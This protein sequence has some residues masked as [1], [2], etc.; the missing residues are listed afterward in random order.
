MPRDQT[1]YA[2][3][4]LAASGT[5]ELERDYVAR[6]L[7][8]AEALRSAVDRCNSLVDRYPSLL[9]RV[10]TPVGVITDHPEQVAQATLTRLRSCLA[11][12]LRLQRRER[13][14]ASER[15]RRLLLRSCIRAMGDAASDL[16]D[17]GQGGSFLC[18]SVY[19]FPGDQPP[20]E[21]GDLPG[22]GNWYSDGERNYY[23]VV[24]LEENRCRHDECCRAHHCEPVEMPDWLLRDWVH[25]DRLLDNA[26]DALDQRIEALQAERRVLRHDPDLEVALESLATLNWYRERTV[27]LTE[28]RR[29][30]HVTGWTLE[31]DPATLHRLLDEAGVDARVLFRAGPPGHRPPVGFGS[32]HAGSPFRQFVTLAGTPDEYEIDP[33][34]MLA[35]LV[36]LLFGFMFPDLG[37]GLL[38]AIGSLLLSR[39]NP[40]LRFLV[41]CGLA[42]A[43]FGVLF[44]ETFGIA[45]PDHGLL[46]SPMDDP[47][48]VL[49][50]SLVMGAVIILIGL[51]L[52]GI[53]AY[54]RGA[55]ARWLWLDAAVLVMF[56]SA[57]LGLLVPAL[58]AVTG[59]ALVWYVAGLLVVGDHGV[60]RGLLQLAFG[61]FELLKN[62]ASFAR[63]GAFALAHS[64]LSHAL[65][66]VAD[67]FEGPFA[68]LIVL[69]IGH[70][71]IVAVE[72]LVVYV[73]TTRLLLFEF[74]TRFL[75]AEGRLF[76]PIGFPGSSR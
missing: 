62:T 72:G 65:L 11:A 20:Q 75:H 5:V 64:A 1:I 10:T 67:M 40:A 54:W 17:F 42:A 36:P 45:W 28:D 48:S 13:D 29:Y 14:A 23:A 12:E 52:S 47:L 32:G 18:R 58:F 73:Q 70:A 61:A 57:L 8:D 43:L 6:P 55:L 63:V 39:H 76:R 26:V 49:L 3:E 71:A 60:G 59:L 33:T 21:L 2:I 31:S 30:C 19:A 46:A 24:C 16:V 27:T 22:L 4:A 56:A 15:R 37:H 44:G 41:P 25:R 68:R 50:A 69:A 35:L 38:L 66:E 7:V 53:E 74:F 9:P 34:P 51:L